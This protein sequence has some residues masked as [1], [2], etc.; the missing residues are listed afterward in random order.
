MRLKLASNGRLRLSGSGK[1]LR[2]ADPTAPT[3]PGG[4][5][6]LTL[7]EYATSYFTAD[8][9]MQRKAGH[10]YADA[11][12]LFTFTGAAPANVQ[13]RVVYKVGG[14]VV[15]DW[16]SLVSVS[17]AG[18]TGVGTL[19]AVP[20]GAD[21][22]LQI[23]DGTQPANGPTISNGAQAWG[24]G[25][26]ALGVGQSNF[27]S[28]VT[29]GNYANIVP[30]SS[31]TE[32]AYFASAGA[33][34]S[35]FDNAGFHGASNG[36]AGPAGSSNAPSTGGGSLK[37]LR[38]VAAGLAA[39]YGRK[40]P[41]GFT[42]WAFNSTGISEYLPST[43]GGKLNTLLYNSGATPGTIGFAS[44]KLVIPAGGDFEIV[45][46]H[47]GESNSS[48][49]RAAYFNS[50]KQ[51]YEE[52]LA[53][54]APRGR[55]A[56]DLAFLPA[57]LGVYGATAGV[58][59]IRGAVLDLDA[60]A[61]ANGWPK[62]R[63]GWNCID[64]DPTDGGDVGLHFRD[65]NEPY[66]TRSMARA[67]Q[68]VLWVLGCAAFS[69]LGPRLGPVVSR[70]GTVATISVVHEGGTLLVTRNGGA[71]SGFYAN[72]LLDFSGTAVPVTMAIASSSTLTAA[73]PEGTVFPVFLKHAGGAAGSVN[74]YHPDISNVVCDNAVYPT[75][76]IGADVQTR[77]PLVPTPD[78][79][80]IN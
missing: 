12:V 76:T 74:S 67:I 48:G 80:T 6:S 27:V 34:G 60:Y 9:V 20:I 23:R 44:S 59:K 72:T 21:Y 68:S 33:A 13:A 1:F 14:A 61:R 65:T 26:M 11:P 24:V 52:L 69:G 53:Y 64:L 7:V 43:A 41:V 47:Q 5:T 10:D 55:T 3:I 51:M 30:G 15:I 78:A 18:D 16:A 4:T 25:V 50:L 70:V 56:A 49:T 19:L 75:G 66:A 62:V 40:I 57:V 2:T 31:L 32:L 42:P 79:I 29:G 36:S 22:A 73:F 58:E 54:V 38:I 17:I 28:T 37:F 71:P 39:K 63:A 45:F 77:L 8:P 35:F 46:M